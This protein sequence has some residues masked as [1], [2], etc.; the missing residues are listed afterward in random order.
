MQNRSFGETG[1]YE[2][3]VG[4]RQTAVQKRKKYDFDKRIWETQV[5]KTKE[6]VLVDRPLLAVDTNNWSTKD[7]HTYNKLLA[8]AD[9]P[10]RIIIIRQHTLNIDDNGVWNAIY[11][12]RAT[13][14]PSHNT[15][16]DVSEKREAIGGEK[17]MIENE[18]KTFEGNVAESESYHIDDRNRHPTPAAM[19][20]PPDHFIDRYW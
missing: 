15:N 8:R 12:D 4:S 17:A 1:P 18:F 3:K 9:G 7:K 6:S 5:F 14:A 13:P 20:H 16:A 2:T 19:E 10:Y 11:V